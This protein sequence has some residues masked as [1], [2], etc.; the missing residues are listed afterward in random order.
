M[1]SIDEIFALGIAAAPVAR[2]KSI[3]LD[4]KADAERAAAEQERRDKFTLKRIE[5]EESQ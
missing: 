3:K 4:A 1:V 2:V 5:G